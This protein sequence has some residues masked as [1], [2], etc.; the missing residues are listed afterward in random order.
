MTNDTLTTLTELLRKLPGVGPR[1]ARRL[2]FWFVRQDSSWIDSFAKTLIEARKKISV[3]EI[4]KRLY[5]EGS[6]LNRCSICASP[7]R[8]ATTVLLVEKD[9][10]LENIERTG[11]YRGRYFV[12]GGTTSPLDKEPEKKIRMNALRLFLTNEAEPVQEIIFALSATS[13]GEDTVLYLE[14]KLRDV[15][16][17]RSLKVTKLG[18]GLSTGTELE[19][20]DKDTMT[21]ALERRT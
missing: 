11:A 14:E 5:S 7:A 21:H 3:C 16:A 12:L 4:C 2:A 19:Y 1:Q 13:E 8:D 6:N 17:T 18:R 9:V 10:D 15:V 20:V